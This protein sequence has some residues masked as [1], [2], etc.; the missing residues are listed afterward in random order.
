MFV[1]L[2]CLLDLLALHSVAI[3]NFPM[4]PVQ[5]LVICRR[6]ICIY[7]WEVVGWEVERSGYN[8]SQRLQNPRAHN[9][10][11][12]NLVSCSVLHAAGSRQRRHATSSALQSGQA[13]AYYCFPCP[14]P[15][16]GKTA[17]PTTA[18][19]GTCT[20][21]QIQRGARL[22]Q[23]VTEKRPCMSSTCASNFVCQS[24]YLRHYV[25]FGNTTILS[26]VTPPCTHSEPL[27]WQY[28]QN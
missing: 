11:F 18:Q 15:A 2:C 6:G 16:W 19:V 17:F 12:A 20:E 27:H 24:V 28:R 14:L 22:G 21:G 8:N 7:H 13:P 9:V 1:P 26:P 10:E 25:Y 4:S 3:I 23:G 5:Q